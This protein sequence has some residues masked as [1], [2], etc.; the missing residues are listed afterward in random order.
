MGG[1]TKRVLGRSAKENE[2]KVR[3][4]TWLESWAKGITSQG[5]W[6]SWHTCACRAVSGAEA[7]ENQ[8]GES[9]AFLRILI[10]NQDK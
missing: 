9:F 6:L 8:R 7:C 4:K 1:N 5:D 3:E 10:F 2:R